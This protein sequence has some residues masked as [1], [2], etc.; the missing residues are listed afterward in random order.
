MTFTPNVALNIHQVAANYNDGND[1]YT[2]NFVRFITRIPMVN[3]TVA[4][5]EIYFTRTVDRRKCFRSIE[6]TSHLILFQVKPAEKQLRLR[7]AM[8]KCGR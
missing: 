1:I 5:F 7:C 4:L 3:K 6:M 2:D 8:R